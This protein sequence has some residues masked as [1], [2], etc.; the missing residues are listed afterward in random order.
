MKEW[1]CANCAHRDE[2]AD[3]EDGTFCLR[4]SLKAPDPD[5]VEDEEELWT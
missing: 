5:R 2:C 4:C 3:R 1:D